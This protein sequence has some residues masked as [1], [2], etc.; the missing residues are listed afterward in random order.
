MLALCQTTRTEMQATRLSHHKIAIWGAVNAS[1]F[2]H[3][4]WAEPIVPG[5]S[6]VIQWFVERPFRYVV[7]DGSSVWGAA[8]HRCA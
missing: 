5:Y 2:V 6:G 1:C 4:D 7:N 8:V 3:K